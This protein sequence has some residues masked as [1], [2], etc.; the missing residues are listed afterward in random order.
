MKKKPDRTFTLRL[1]DDIAHTADIA[2]RAMD[3]PV[4]ELIREA[5]MIRIADLRED[6]VFQQHLRELIERDR[7]ILE[8][9]AVDD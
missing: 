8:R 5:I 9:L 3:I 2:A 1:P 4:S 6:D 7:E